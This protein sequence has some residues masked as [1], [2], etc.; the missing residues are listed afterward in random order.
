LIEA[1]SD[2]SSEAWMMQN[3]LH[4]QSRDLKEKGCSIAVRGL[5]LPD[6]TIDK[7]YVT[8]GKLL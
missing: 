7:D 2:F 8:Y 1:V 4:L 3:G 6:A 5:L